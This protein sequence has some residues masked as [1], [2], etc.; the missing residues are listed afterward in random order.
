MRAYA[1]FRSLSCEKSWWGTQ[2]RKVRWL[3][4]RYYAGVDT[5]D[6]LLELLNPILVRE[7]IRLR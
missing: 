5:V 1:I 4:A 2:S 6:E 3:A 7:V